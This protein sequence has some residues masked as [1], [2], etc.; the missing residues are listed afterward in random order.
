M[1][2]MGLLL[3]LFVHAAVIP[4]TLRAVFGTPREE[5]ILG[6]V[7]L[8]YRRTQSADSWRP[9]EAARTYAAEWPG[10]DIYEEIFFRRKVKFQYAPTSLLY[11]GHFSR[12]TLNRLSWVAVWVTVALTVMVFRD[13]LQHASRP[14]L[15]P[16]APSAL[17]AASLAAGCLGLT[18]YPLIKGYTLG[19]IQVWVD[20]LFAAVVWAW[21][22]GWK[23]TAGTALGLACLIKPPLAPVAVWAV[24]RREWRVAAGVIATCAVG[25]AASIATYGIASHLTYPRVLAFIAARGEAYHPN[26]SFN[27]LLNRWF[28]NGDSLVFQDYEFSPPHPF[29]SAGT[30]VAAI[31]LLAL[32][33]VLPAFCRRR[34][35]RFD[36]PIIALTATMVSPIAW[37]HHYGIVL[38]LFAVLV[39]ASLEVSACGRWTAALLAVSFVLTAQFL[40]PVQYVAATALN[41]LQSYLL[42]GALLLLG[43]AYAGAIRERPECDGRQR[44][45]P[46]QASR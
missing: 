11:I 35:W 39:P 42:F 36:L 8:F 32:A 6:Q 46:T 5:T 2:V 45:R 44:E 38:P 14:G 12:S 1:V 30:T 43:V 28:R 22:R 29:V 20:A 17:F 25:L 16:V 21:S 3:V 18:F 13:A 27:G 4:L 40:A 7:N 9:M 10:R 23:A 34:D 41:P 15:Q 37:E 24:A 33:F 31:V 19:Q 26:Q